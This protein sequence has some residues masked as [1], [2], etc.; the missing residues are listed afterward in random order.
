MKRTL[1]ASLALAGI[2]VCQNQIAMPPHATTYN[3]YSRGWSTTAQ[4]GFLITELDLPLDA[5][6]AGDT[7]AFLININGVQVHHSTGNATLPLVLAS[8]I[9]VMPNDV[10]RVVGNWS[11]AAPTNFTAHNSYAS[12]GGTYSTPIEGAA[13]TLFR[14]GQ[15]WDV[16]DPAFGGTGFEGLSGS[17]GRVLVTT[18]ALAN[19]AAKT[20]YGTGCDDRPRMVHEVFPALAVPDL[21]NTS[22]FMF[23]I[24]DAN[25]GTYT[26][27][28]GGPAYDGATP[29][30]NGVDLLLGAFTSSSSA[31]W[32]DG[33]VVQT[34]PATFAAG[35]PFPSAGSLT[36]AD[37]T[38]N[39]NGK[40]YL[41]NTTDA[42]F[43]TNGSNYASLAP[44]AGTTGAGL[45]V[46]SPFNVDLDPT[47]GGNIWYEDPS[48]NGG[49][50]I[51]W[52]NILNWQAAAGPPAVLN[53]LQI[54]LLP[55][56]QVN[57]A[58]GAS[59]GTGG[60]N[61][62]DAI[63]GYSAGGGE[64]IS[65]AVDWS[66]LAGHVSGNGT[67]PLSLDADA[68]PVIGT[69]INLVIDNIP[70]ASPLA[71]LI[72]SLTKHDPGIDLTASGMPGCFQYVNFDAVQLVIAPGTSHLSPYPVPNDPTLSGV[73]I[74]LQAAAYN[75]ASI[76]NALG[77][78]SS[79]GLELLVD[80]N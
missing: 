68:R 2:A 57:I 32:D 54:E 8:P 47:V 58:Y 59:L 42:S 23:Y 5:Q 35:F 38:I 44:F 75:P 39:S 77:A 51:T 36:T 28:P 30:T 46:L 16:G 18:T 64:P 78:T 74:K 62:N 37:I 24:A 1:F 70:A 14:A 41:G 71:G 3:G 52:D 72:F 26:I 19:F 79:N 40:L 50:R 12:G 55:S 13:H 48:P 27:V 4:G 53:S 45:P 11:P 61:N 31:S 17:I 10:L 67:M 25:G 69:T 6:Q 29:A 60:S 33:S 34:L 22:W 56:G 43:A 15:Q 49:V 76:P 73:L 80:V 66:A 63:V 7:A 65:S 21:M 20:P 9:A